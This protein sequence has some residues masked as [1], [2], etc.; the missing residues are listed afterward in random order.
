MDYSSCTTNILRILHILDYII[1]LDVVFINRK[2]AYFNATIN[3]D[4][5]YAIKKKAGSSFGSNTLLLTDRNCTNI[6]PLVHYQSHIFLREY[7]HYRRNFSRRFKTKPLLRRT[8]F[9]ILPLTRM[10]IVIVHSLSAD[11]T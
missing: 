9:P 6:G 7:K 2:I 8:S 11:G 4:L 1:G 5:F 3:L 10:L